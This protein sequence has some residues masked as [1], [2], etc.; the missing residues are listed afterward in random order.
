MSKKSDE[1]IENAINEKSNNA[2]KR[3]IKR[4]IKLPTSTNEKKKDVEEKTS[5]IIS[6]DTIKAEKEK[7]GSVAKKTKRTLHLSIE[8][9]EN[10]NEVP[11]NEVSETVEE[12][13]VQKVNNEVSNVETIPVATNFVVS[14]EDEKDIILESLLDNETT[15]S[16]ITPNTVTENSNFLNEPSIFEKFD[17]NINNKVATNSM[18]FTKE[19]TINLNSS[20]F[21]A[22][23]VFEQ[24]DI[25]ITETDI[26]DETNEEKVVIED[27]NE[28]VINKD[29]VEDVLDATEEEIVNKVEKNTFE[30]EI[31]ETPVLDAPV[32]LNDI[33]TLDNELETIDDILG[34]STEEEFSDK[35]FNLPI[36]NEETTI[37]ENISNTTTSVE[38][39]LF[40]NEEIENNDKTNY[41]EVAENTESNIEEVADNISTIENS[42]S[43]P[44]GIFIENPT[45]NDNATPSTSLFSKAKKSIVSNIT[46]VFKKFTY[47]EAN[48]INSEAENVI[49]EIPVQTS[50][51]LTDIEQ[52]LGNYDS[53]NEKNVNELDVTAEPIG[54]NIPVLDNSIEINSVL[55][56][57]DSYTS[58]NNI[59]DINIISVLSSDSQTPDLTDEELLELLDNEETIENDIEIP[60][61][62]ESEA[63]INEI[64]QDNINEN[65]E[66]L[67]NIINSILEENAETETNNITNDIVNE[68][69]ENIEE[70]SDKTDENI[71]EIESQEEIF[72]EQDIDDEVSEDDDFSI[73]DYFGIEK[74]ENQNVSEEL[75]NEE[76]F[77][78]EINFDNTDSLEDDNADI[79]FDE[80]L[81]SVPELDNKEK[82]S[83]IELDSLSK[84]FDSLTGTISSLSNRIT[85]LENTKMQPVEKAS[86][87]ETIE[88]HVAQNIENLEK[89]ENTA[90][91]ENVENTEINNEPVNNVENE[92]ISLD[93]INLDDLTEMELLDISDEPLEN[94]EPIEEV[95]NNETI[96]NQEESTPI[97]NGEIKEEI[98]SEDIN[99]DDINLDDISLDDINIDDINLETE[100]PISIE[101]I[102]SDALS[103][104]SGMNSDMKEELLSEVL[105]DN[106]DK[107]DNNIPEES[108]KVLSDD[109]EPL[110]DF[111]KIVDSLSKTITE[112]EQS[113]P[114]E[115]PV[116]TEDSI[117]KAFNILINKDDTF[118]IS[119]LNE[120]Y[121]I[122]ADFDGI[123]VLSENIHISTPKNNFFVKVGDKYIEIHNHQTYFLVHTNFEDI[124][125][126]NAINNV[127]FAKKNNRIE[128]NVKEAFKL[129]SVNNKIELSM[130][131]TSI[132]G[133]AGS[134]ANTD[135]NNN[136]IC[137]N[138]TLLISEETQKV[139]LPYAIEDVVKKLNDSSNGY[140]SVDEVVEKEY[141]LPLSEFKMPII[142]RFREAYRFMRTKEKSSVY[143]AVDLALELMFNSNLNPAVIRAAKDLKELNIYLDCLYENEL[144]KFD[145][146]KIIYKVL[147]KIQ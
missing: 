94:S 7:K 135:N 79:E 108:D 69:I 32:S 67:E 11:T 68:N 113:T 71:E 39:E 4:T 128:L 75:E 54:L 120:T 43:A 3:S 13:I 49:D 31:N 93:D 21:Y 100:N 27:K 132:A 9:E 137:D 33:I 28:T 112:L 125:F 17:I 142:S 63:P 59:N 96:K 20:F 26:P 74:E 34:T 15:S 84:L 116:N 138:K 14:A 114:V 44:V 77:S 85:E 91:I 127:S 50:P 92:E 56:S 102:L 109:E 90:I 104:D 40:A 16:S 146:F 81:S 122:V 144:D 101:D 60:L 110:S 65:D 10:S 117:G 61:E 147:P 22:P 140:Q 45:N 107:T 37:V 80:E 139:Y 5:N 76:D 87:A 98:S 52:A 86:T 46:S 103:S 97:D 134:P 89:I 88:E 78:E 95:D 136:S 70:I 48:L 36:N 129:S 58:E 126:A 57:S 29:E 121:E 55:D 143:A 25:E 53:K 145:C 24:Y 6:L 99:I 8:K 131:N 123:S 133:I 62:N 118:S 119:V 106:S 130:L 35:D 105:N 47:D 73:E 42:T 64:D 18:S 66:T 141:T 111:L 38:N 72:E 2:S 115:Q 51:K 30:E 12:N 41:L 82:V 1:L 83:G 124:E 19:P 23:S